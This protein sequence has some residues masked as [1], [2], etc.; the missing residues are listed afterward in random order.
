MSFFCPKYWAKDLQPYWHS[1]CRGARIMPTFLAFRPRRGRSLLCAF[2][3]LICKNYANV[4]LYDC[5]DWAKDLQDCWHRSCN[6]ARIMPSFLI[7]FLVPTP[8]QKIHKWPGLAR[9]VPIP[10]H[11]R[12]SRA[13]PAHPSIHTRTLGKTFTCA[14][15]LVWAKDSQMVFQFYIYIGYSTMLG[16]HSPSPL[17]AWRPR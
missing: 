15:S 13:S 6:I 2:C 16:D 12:A 1:S 5:V 7:R 4:C 11:S 9:I 8:G 3:K 10:S 17:G 14:Y